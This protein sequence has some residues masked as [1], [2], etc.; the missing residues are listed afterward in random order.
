MLHV[1]LGLRSCLG[2]DVGVTAVGLA[3]GCCWGVGAGSPACLQHVQ[4]QHGLC[5]V[6]SLLDLICRH[7]CGL[8]T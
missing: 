3:A 6:F 1:L 5:F 4:R 8:L 2:A 7:G